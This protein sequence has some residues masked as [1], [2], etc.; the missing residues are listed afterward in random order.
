[1][2]VR[3][4]FIARSAARVRLVV[5]QY[6]SI[7]RVNQKIDSAAKTAAV[8]AARLERDFDM[9]GALWPAFCDPVQQRLDL[10]SNGSAVERIGYVPVG[11]NLIDFAQVCLAGYTRPGDAQMQRSPNHRHVGFSRYG[12]TRAY[13]FNLCDRVLAAQCTARPEPERFPIAR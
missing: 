7:F 13:L 1:M 5:E 4:I 8:G 11:E 2:L 10:A 9:D 12:H 6:P 3:D